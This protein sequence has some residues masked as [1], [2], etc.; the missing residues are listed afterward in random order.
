MSEATSKELENG[1]IWIE[2]IRK[3]DN[4][5]RGDIGYEG[6]DREVTERKKLSENGFKRFAN[7]VEKVVEG[8]D[9]KEKTDIFKN[10]FLLR[11]EAV[12]QSNQNN[13]LFQEIELDPE[14]L[15]IDGQEIAVETPVNIFVQ[16]LVKEHKNLRLTKSQRMDTEKLFKVYR[17]TDGEGSKQNDIYIITDPEETIRLGN[18]RLHLK[19]VDI[20]KEP[21][22]DYLKER[23]KDLDT[24][25]TGLGFDDFI[26]QNQGRYLRKTSG[27]PQESEEK[28]KEL[29]NGEMRDILLKYFREKVQL[30]EKLEK[31]LFPLFVTHDSTKVDTADVMLFEPH[32][33]LFTNSSVGKSTTAKKIGYVTDEATPAGLIGYISADEGVKRGIIHGRTKPIFADEINFHGETKL[34]DNLLELLEQGENRQVKAAKEMRTQFYSSLVYMGNPVDDRS[35]ANKQELEPVESF[36]MMLDSVGSNLQALG[37]RLGWIIFDQELDTAGGK[38]EVRLKRGEREK[39]EIVT[40]WIRKE[41]SGEYTKIHE[42]LKE[43]LGQKYPESYHKKIDKI[44][45]NEKM[46]DF[47]QNHK[48][49]YRHTRG[50]ALKGAVLKNLSDIINKSY[51]LEDIKRDAEDCF[52]D[53]L[54]VNKETMAKLNAEVSFELEKEQARAILEDQKPEY[55]KLFVKRVVAYA[56]EDD[57]EEYK[58]ASEL[59]TVWEDIREEI[60]EV[61]KDSKYWKWSRIENSVKDKIGKSNRILIE[62]YGLILSNSEDVLMVKRKDLGFIKYRRAANIGSSSISEENDRYRRSLESQQEGD[63]SDQRNQA[64][65]GEI[66]GGNEGTDLKPEEALRKRLG[67]E[68]DGDGN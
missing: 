61:E 41:V 15:E 8:V 26:E 23:W 43:W 19:P 34:N 30:D 52:E 54:D 64:I 6:H 24:D 12:E 48:E 1:K 39:L 59:K 37:S 53:I 22:R 62:R 17:A 58:S 16:E 14:I 21:Y 25:G 44:D 55:L 63:R 18:Q 32:G 50:L 38:G 46:E 45:F 11:N 60:E 49:A 42:E 35:F 31:V 47:W 13:S 67:Q 36:Q 10:L 4:G 65:S 20:S 5:T 40:N 33:F 56:R 68:G 3:E 9:E 7:L 27:L 29:D 66:E 2:N 51:N 28:L 57:I